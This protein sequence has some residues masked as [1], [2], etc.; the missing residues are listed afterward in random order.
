MS[1]AVADV[2]A[3]G[4]CSAL[5]VPTVSTFPVASIILTKRDKKPVLFRK[6]G[7]FQEG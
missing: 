2:F 7:G 1:E 6:L 4:E 3:L 5:F